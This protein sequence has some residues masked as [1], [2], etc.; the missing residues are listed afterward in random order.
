MSLI[1]LVEFK[2]LGDER[3]NLVSLEG[4]RNIPFDIKRIYY[5]Y[6]TIEN[7][8]RGFHAHVNLQQIVICTSGS[9]RFLIDDGETKEEIV[10][11]SPSQGL[12]IDGIKWREMHNFSEDCVLM[13]LASEYYNEQDYIRDY[14]EFTRI[15]N[16]DS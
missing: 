2:V 11:N 13:V 16:N 5:I 8:S 15:V 7:V 9:C 1:D 4:N 12:F 6:G 3:G 10:L 14:N